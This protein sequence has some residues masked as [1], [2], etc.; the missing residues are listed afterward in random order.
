MWM[1]VVWL[2]LFGCCAL[3]DDPDTFGDDLDATLDTSTATAT[4]WY[5]DADADGY[6]KGAIV[7][8]SCLPVAGAANNGDDC[9]DTDDAIH[10]AATEV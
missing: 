9:D 7:D 3:G 6:G 8:R 1:L 2:G 5:A 4:A 10:P